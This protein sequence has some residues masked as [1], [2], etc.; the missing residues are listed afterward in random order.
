MKPA[1]PVV[2][3]ITT[4]KASYIEL[5][6]HCLRSWKSNPYIDLLALLEE[7]DW[8]DSV[9]YRELITD[10]VTMISTYRL[11]GSEIDENTRKRSP[12]LFT[13]FNSLKAYRGYSYYGFVNS[14]IEL[15]ASDDFLHKVSSASEHSNLV[16]YPR[17]DYGNYLVNSRLYRLG[18]DFFVAPAALVYSLDI[19]PALKGFR[20]GE[21]GWD[22]ILPLS[23]PK[24]RIRFSD[25]LYLYHRLHPSGSTEMWDS[26]I[27]TCLFNIHATWVSAV[28][29]SLLI[30]SLKLLYRCSISL[31]EWLPVR[32]HLKGLISYLISRCL[33]RLFIKPVLLSEL[34]AKSRQT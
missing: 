16:L 12:S 14:D 25:N 21:V 27:I 10:C 33:L 29:Y 3:I 31:E 32:L 9:S 19:P 23:M 13:V 18:F 28:P 11:S 4:F 8:R 22:Y 30:A 26:A 24:S 17:R 15:D 34:V 1:Q 7:E 5:I 20:V 6:S 2:L